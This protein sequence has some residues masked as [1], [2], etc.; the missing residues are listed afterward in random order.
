MKNSFII[1]L[2]VLCFFFTTTIQAQTI[3]WQRSMMESSADYFQIKNE[4][5]DYL[6]ANPDP[7]EG[8]E[9]S[10][11]DRWEYFWKSRI[12][13]KGNPANHFQG[14]FVAMRD[15]V[16][17]RSTYCV[18]SQEF[19]GNW[20]LLGP[21]SMPTQSMGMISALWIDPND[22]HNILA[23]S[24][25]GG[26]WRSDHNSQT[27]VYTWHCIT[28]G[29]E[30]LPAMGIQAIA[31]D[32]NNSEII[33]IASGLFDQGRGGYGIG[34]AKSTDNGESWSICQTFLD[35][36]ATLNI[37]TPYAYTVKFKPGS[38]TIL[39]AT[40]KNHILKSADAGV[41]WSSFT[42]TANSRMEFVDLDFMFGSP[43]VIFASGS[44]KG[45]AGGGAGVFRSTD[46]GNTWNQ[47]S[48]IFNFSTEFIQNGSFGSGVLSPW[49]TAGS[50]SG[51]NQWHIFN[52]A[53]DYKAELTP[54][55]NNEQYL[56]Q[57]EDFNP[58]SVK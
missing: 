53:G 47:L 31:V 46:A 55:V 22:E 44:D 27:G 43:D 9:E 29:E 52:D 28:D 13:V 16:Q 25:S 45:G 2:L 30:G 20:T 8:G 11:F 12:A 3:N 36:L 14:G 51:N 35:K 18:S 1:S 50:G 19:Q 34:L 5:Q 58:G 15:F 40:V 56:Y 57:A 7:D 48:G 42:W 54:V 33:W 6:S 21:V 49:L 37:P 17:N 24:S 26:L 23:G 39:Y 4:A 32:A 41:T 10:Q 38:S